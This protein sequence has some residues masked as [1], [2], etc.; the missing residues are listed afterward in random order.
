MYIC[1][2]PFRISSSTPCWFSDFDHDHLTNCFFY[3]ETELS[4]AGPCRLY[5]PALRGLSQPTFQIEKCTLVQIECK[6]FIAFLRTFALRFCVNS[7]EKIRSSVLIF[8]GKTKIYQLV[9]WSMAMLKRP[10]ASM[11]VFVLFMWYFYAEAFDQFILARVPWYNWHM[12]RAWFHI[13]I[14]KRKSPL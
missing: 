14:H 2:A 13:H 1:M 3:C 10:F 4:Y 12:P 7:L 6:L 8:I 9:V 11:N 5:F